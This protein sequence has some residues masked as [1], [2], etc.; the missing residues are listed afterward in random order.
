MCLSILKEGVSWKPGISIPQI[1]CGIQTLLEEP[2]NG[3]A[4]QQKAHDVFRRDKAEYLRLVAR[5]PHG[6]PPEP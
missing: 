1:L 6:P 2:N 3:D 4:A 5:T